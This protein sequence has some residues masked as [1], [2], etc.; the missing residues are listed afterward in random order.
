MTTHQAV[1]RLT[2]VIRR[3]HLAYST[4]QSYVA[5]LKRYCAFV[6]QVPAGLPS[7]HKI[8]RFLTA[9]AKDAVSA[10][11]QNQAFNAILF[12]YKDALG[13]ELKASQALRAKRPV[14]LRHAPTRA[15]VFK[16]LKTIHTDA[17]MATGLV[18]RLL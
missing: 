15:D 16:L 13:V 11:T 14:Q 4:E 10:S 3:K 18:V 5:W 7:E 12:F 17:P 8:E 2:D 6:Q 1:E 9:L